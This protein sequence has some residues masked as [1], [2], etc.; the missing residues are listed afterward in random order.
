MATRTSLPFPRASWWFLALFAAAVLAFWPPYVSRVTQVDEFWI[1]LHTIGVVAW[2]ALLI[3]QPLLIHRR[4]WPLHR[5]LGA[6]SYVLVPYVAVTALLLAHSRFKAM[7]PA[8]FAV[9]A[10]NLYLPLI[11]LLLFL[12]CYALAVRHRRD[13]AV[14][15]RFMVATALPLIDPIMARFL[16]FYTPVPDA[17]FVYPLI[18][19]GFTDLVLVLLIWL[20]R[21]ERR[22]RWVFPA[23]LAI[24]VAAHLGRFTLAESDAWVDFATWFRSLPLT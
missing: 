21:G 11:A 4:K 19:Y 23:L 8:T 17:G 5:R 14:H 9:A 20:D 2:M 22:A 7:D 12:L 1:H 6:L 13:M 18:G 24:F 16:Y 3:G 10:P 15:S